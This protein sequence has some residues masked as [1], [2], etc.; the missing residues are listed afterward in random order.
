MAIVPLVPGLGNWVDSDR[1]FNR[2]AEMKL[3]IM[4]L[5]EGTNLSLVAQ[6]RIGKTSLMREAAR[7]ISDQVIVLH[8]DLEKCESPEDAIVALSMEAR[9]YS[10]LLKKIGHVFGEVLGALETVKISEV[11][12]TLRGGLSAANWKAKGDEIF[13]ALAAAGKS[14]GR[15]VVI[16]FD[17]VP[18]L[19]NRLLRGN[20]DKITPE[21]RGAAD[22]FMSWL[23]DNAIRHKGRVVQV[24]T[25]S[26]G[27]EPILRQAGLSGTLN[28]HHSFELRPWSSSTGAQCFLRS[29]R[30]GNYR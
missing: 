7:R 12:I 14:E 21:R 26:I 5:V 8:V 24:I 18:I 17:E 11:A 20:E 16:F 29:Q 23:R 25:G 30:V 22:T 27:L 3:F 6:R 2:D 9:P 28:V 1:F 13:D 10:K 4:H 19:V 15:M